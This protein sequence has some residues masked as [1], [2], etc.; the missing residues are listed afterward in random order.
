MKLFK[1]FKKILIKDYNCALLRSVKQNTIIGGQLLFNTVRY[2][3][4]WSSEERKMTSMETGYL[5]SGKE[6]WQSNDKAECMRDQRGFILR[7]GF[8]E[9]IGEDLVRWMNRGGGI[10]VWGWRALGWCN[11]PGVL[12]WDLRFS[13]VIPKVRW[14]SKGPWGVI[15]LFQAQGLRSLHL[16]F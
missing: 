10:L 9:A 5:Y 15:F 14:F 11:L 1:F 13:F 2:S 4:I 7:R 6:G 16:L 12:G 3:L 8:A